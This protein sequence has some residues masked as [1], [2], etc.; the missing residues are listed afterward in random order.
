MISLLRRYTMIREH[1]QF[2]FTE[3]GKAFRILCSPFTY[4]VETGR[5]ASLPNLQPGGNRF[6]TQ[7]AGN[8]AVN[9]VSVKLQ[10]PVIEVHTPEPSLTGKLRHWN[11]V[12]KYG[13]YRNSLVLSVSVSDC[14][15]AL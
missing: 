5:Y 1:L 4:G 3:V 10:K 2:C 15:L 11:Q 13:I 7:A 9:A 14:S 6:K 8:A 12:C